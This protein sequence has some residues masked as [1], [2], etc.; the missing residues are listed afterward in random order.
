M[1]KFMTKVCLLFFILFHVFS[2]LPVLSRETQEEANHDEYW[3]LY[4]EREKNEELLLFLYNPATNQSSQ[5]FS[6]IKKGENIDLVDLKKKCKEEINNITNNKE[7]NYKFF[8]E[9]EKPEIKELTFKSYNDIDKSSKFYLFDLNKIT[10]NLPKINHPES[11]YAFFLYYF[12][13]QEVVPIE[14]EK[15]LSDFMKKGLSKE[16]IVDAYLTF[17]NLRIDNYCELIKFIDENRINI[18]DGKFANI[19]LYKSLIGTIGEIFERVDENDNRIENIFHK[20]DENNLANLENSIKKLNKRINPFSLFSVALILILGSFAFLYIN[21]MNL[22][23][24]NIKNRLDVENFSKRFQQLY[25]EIDKVY[26]NQKNST[27]LNPLYKKIKQL[28]T[29]IETIYGNNKLLENKL[30]ENVSNISDIKTSVL[31][32]KENQ[33]RGYNE[34]RKIIIEIEK[35]IFSQREELATEHKS[36]I[37]IDEYKEKHVDI[38]RKFYSLS[39]KSVFTDKI[40]ILNE[41]QFPKIAKKIESFNENKISGFVKLINGLMVDLDLLEGDESPH[42]IK[43]I[44]EQ[45]ILAFVDNMDDFIK[46]HNLREDNS[47]LVV[48]YENYLKELLEIFGVEEIQINIKKEIFNGD[49]FQLVNTVVNQKFPLG[50]ILEIHKRGFIFNNFVLRKPWV[51]Q[52][53]K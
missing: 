35:E 44:I 46:K 28:D 11:I 29:S 14:I 24:I 43:K 53:S 21:Y 9:I 26:L 33:E 13:K 41:K 6:Q 18:K 10:Q 42:E 22:H 50:T 30:E 19:L 47:E 39:N 16:D 51:T 34:L 4:S 49:K 23:R 52:S 38:L 32:L 17:L 25:E 31:K 40:V 8:L 45:K 37:S 7:L 12:K 5:K 2:F 48:E 20:L 36:K 15:K 27:Q 1:I 3:L